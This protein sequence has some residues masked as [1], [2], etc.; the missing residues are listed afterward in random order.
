VG[1]QRP[2]LPNNATS[3]SRSRADLFQSLM[4][5]YVDEDTR[6]LA[7]EYVAIEVG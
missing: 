5:L 1:F 3:I 7:D 4:R 2:F 6:D